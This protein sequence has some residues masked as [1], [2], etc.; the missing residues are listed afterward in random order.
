MARLRRRSRRAARGRRPRDA[1]GVG[2]AR[3]RGAG[4]RRGT[5]AL[6][7]RLPCGPCS[8]A[9]ARPARRCGLGAAAPGPGLPGRSAGRRRRGGRRWSAGRR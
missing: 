6:L 3:P 5:G 1:R 7:H 4:R 2:R 8:A 9:R